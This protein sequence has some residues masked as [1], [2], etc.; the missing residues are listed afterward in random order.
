MHGG[1]VLPSRDLEGWQD[2]ARR[3]EQVGFWLYGFIIMAVSV[4]YSH[5]TTQCA[6]RLHPGRPWRRMA[7]KLIALHRPVVAAA[8]VEGSAF[9][10]WNNVQM[11]LCE[12]PGGFLG[13]GCRDE[14]GLA[15]GTA[16]QETCSK[17][18]LG[19]CRR[20]VVRDW[21]EHTDSCACGLVLCCL[22]YPPV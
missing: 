12:Y 4:V 17:E 2:A 11:G 13:G 1:E 8:K 10:K 14:A 3:L 21:R 22:L 9:M 20:A 7:Q 6:H 5:V 18:N 15:T 19:A 16:R